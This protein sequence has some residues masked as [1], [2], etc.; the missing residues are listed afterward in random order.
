MSDLA[1][2]STGHRQTDHLKIMHLCEVAADFAAQVLAPG[3][4][5]LAKVLRGGTENDLLVNLKRDFDRVHHV[6]PKASR[7]DSAEL[8]VLAR[9]F[10]GASISNPD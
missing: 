10:R 2:S 5:F 4:A 9:G 6:K 8:Y 1:A 7:Q 3:G